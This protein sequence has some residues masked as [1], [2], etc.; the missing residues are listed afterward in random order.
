MRSLLDNLPIKIAA[1]LLGLLLWFHVATEKNYH[2]QVQLAVTDIVLDTDLTLSKSPPDS[3]EVIV[4]ASGKQLLRRSWRREGLRINASALPAGRHT[5]NLSPVNVG[6][7]SANEEVS[8]QSVVFP[9]SIELSIDR[10]SETTLPV[11]VDVT[12]L[13]DDGFAVKG[14]SVP[15]PT[16]AK[17]TGPRSLL[18]SFTTVYTV[19][20]ELSGLRNNLSLTLPLQAPEGYGVKVDP[21]SVQLDIEVVPIR[22]RVFDNVP[23]VLFNQPEGFTI[24]YTPQQLRV[25]ITGPPEVVDSLDASALVASADFARVTPGGKARVKIDCPSIVRVKEQST[26]SIKVTVH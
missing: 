22:T 21:D 16:E 26:D 13:P 10:L 15:Q 7:V 9:T 5:L 11:T 14:I 8:L 12:T 23:I 6:M 20:R 2:H 3:L 17:V 24:E 25:A 19:H 1:I 18:N 4:S